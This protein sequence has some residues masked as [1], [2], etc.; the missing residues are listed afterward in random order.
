MYLVKYAPTDLGNSNKAVNVGI[1]YERDTI[2][3][4]FR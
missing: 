4:S 3:Y 2:I 1:F